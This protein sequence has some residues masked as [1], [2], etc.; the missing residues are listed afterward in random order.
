MQF[1]HGSRNGNLT[2][3]SVDKSKDGKIWMTDDYNFAVMYGASSIRSWKWTGEKLM[4][5]ELYKPDAFEIQ[6]K[7]QPFYIYKTE[8]VSN[9]EISIS[10]QKRYQKPFY[11]TTHNVKLVSKQ[12]IPDA[13]EKLLELH[14]KG[15]IILYFWEDSLKENPTLAEKLKQN[16]KES[17][18][19]YIQEGDYEKKFPDDYKFCKKLFPELFEEY[20]KGLTK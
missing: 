16:F 18:I 9:F 13:Y 2:E 6:F 12:L 19:K 5:F 4:I 8:D 10:D 20:E 7:G 11:T 17:I 15:E 1:Y 14:K 3:L